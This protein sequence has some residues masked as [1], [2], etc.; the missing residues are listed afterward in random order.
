M[1]TARR[2]YGCGAFFVSAT[3]TLKSIADA[4]RSEIREDRAVAG[5]RYN[6][7]TTAEA[8]SVEVAKVT[9]AEVT[10]TKVATAKTS[11][12]EMAAKVATAEC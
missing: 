6:D 7:V 1:A 9:T 10:S 2:P 5:I 4:A 11:T 3:V 8:A 12:A